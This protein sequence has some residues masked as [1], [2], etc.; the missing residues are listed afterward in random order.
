MMHVSL[1]ER[2]ILA[3]NVSVMAINNDPE[4]NWEYRKYGYKH[5]Y[6]YFGYNNYELAKSSHSQYLLTPYNPIAIQGQ[7]TLF[8]KGNHKYIVDHLNADI[9]IS[10]AGLE[11]IKIQ[12]QII[13]LALEISAR[14]MY[15]V[16]RWHNSPYRGKILKFVRDSE[17]YIN[18][19][20]NKPTT[21]EDITYLVDM[22]IV[23]LVN[24]F[25]YE[26]YYAEW[27]R[28]ANEALDLIDS[29]ETI[30]MRLNRFQVGGLSSIS[31]SD[32]LE[33][34]EI[35]V[36]LVVGDDHIMNYE[37]WY[38][39]ADLVVHYSTGSN[40]IVISTYDDKIAIRALKSEDGLRAFAKAKIIGEEGW[41]GNTKEIKSPPKI[42]KSYRDA[43]QVF[44]RLVEVIRLRQ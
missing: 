2:K 27:K 25:D 36:A 20:L 34:R 24:D 39:V 44:N 22:S 4:K 38:T 18:T 23:I 31:D 37:A 9:L 14:G 32:I 16:K 26:Y 19:I 15:A 35:R 17:P 12:P 28:R 5:L 6:D 33:D 42:N 29:F 3:P 41:G 30:P 10:I 7:T 43:R 1:Y 8:G 21:C 40:R 13:D 11:G